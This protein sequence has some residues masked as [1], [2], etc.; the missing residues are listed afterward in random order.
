MDFSIIIPAHNEEVT[1]R[2]TLESLVAQTLLPKQLVVVNDNSTD[3]TLKVAK[4]FANKYPWISVIDISSSEE[5]QPG[6][7]VVNAFYKGLETLDVAY[8]IICKF[9]ADLIFPPNYL[10]KVAALFKSNDTI[11]IAGGILYIEKND[12]W[13]YE[14]I[15][16]QTHVRGPIKAYRK[17]CFEEIGGLKRSIGWDTVDTLLAQYHGWQMATD[18][19]LKVKHL[20]PTGAQYQKNSKYKQGEAMYKMRYGIT[21]TS[22]A[23]LKL[24]MKKKSPSLFKDY[25]MGYFKAKQNGLEYL[26]S[27]PEGDF[28]R[29]LR[30]KG[31]LGR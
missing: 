14:N 15:A 24:A 18:T 12:N 31:I 30:W 16:K 19:N 8:D 1:L 3:A 5:H 29:S 20:K 13:V 7:K 6:S 10:E 9:D 2:V 11:G 25:L 23:A 17:Q 22:I 28:I 4:E 27:K 26:V 21:I